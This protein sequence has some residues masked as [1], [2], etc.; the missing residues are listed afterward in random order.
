MDALGDLIFARAAPSEPIALLGDFNVAP[1]PRDVYSVEAMEGRI[2]FTV[3]ERSTLQRLLERGF[4]DTFRQLRSEAGLYSWWD[5]RMNMF[6]RKLGLRI[7][8]VW[9]TPDLAAQAVDAFVDIEERAKERT[10]DHAP[11]V[12]DFARG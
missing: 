8:H 11:V 7:D 12:V 2:H 5:Y 1:D 3:E 10:S 6:K 9:A 4:V